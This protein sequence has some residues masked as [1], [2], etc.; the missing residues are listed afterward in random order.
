MDL[1]EMKRVIAFGRV[2]KLAYAR[3]GLSGATKLIGENSAPL[4]TELDGTFSG[5]LICYNK[6]H[7]V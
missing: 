6:I 1:D 5:A 3:A 2:N 7:R 4:C